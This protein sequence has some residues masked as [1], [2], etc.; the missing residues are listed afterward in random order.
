MA[1]GQPLRSFLAH[2]ERRRREG[3]SFGDRWQAED[4]PGAFNELAW[5]PGT[6]ELY[7]CSLAGS[8]H[9]RWT[10]LD[11]P[12]ANVVTVLAVIPSLRQVRRLLAGWQNHAL[13]YGN[14][15]WVMA[16]L[17]KPRRRENFGPDLGIGQRRLCRGW[18]LRLAHVEGPAVDVAVGSGGVALC[19]VDPN[20]EGR[21]LYAP[22]SQVAELTAGP[23]RWPEHHHHL[24]PPAAPYCYLYL[25]IVDEQHPRVLVVPGAGPNMLNRRVDDVCATWWLGAGDGD[26]PA[27]TVSP[28]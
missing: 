23:W 13:D 4:R 22:W 25:H 10:R 1:K 6:G 21:E 7:T 20:G 11:H 18:Q 19:Q 9:Y 5:L 14:L 12:A 17:G 27:A 15:D 16:A 2:D 8:A 3:V 28:S 24:A 26:G